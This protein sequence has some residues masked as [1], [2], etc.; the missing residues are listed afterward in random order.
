MGQGGSVAA[1]RKPA[2]LHAH[3]HLRL[4]PG[5]CQ[6]SL[7]PLHAV[8]GAHDGAVGLL[9]HSLHGAL[10][11]QQLPRPLV[12]GLDERSLRRRGRVV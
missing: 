1:G 4:L 8:G 12:E 11:L 5:L 2:L 3:T 6:S 9:L 7:Q 10:L